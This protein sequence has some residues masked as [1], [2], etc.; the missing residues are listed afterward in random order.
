MFVSR[1]LPIMSVFVLCNFQMH[2]MLSSNLKQAPR[3]A[4]L[5]TQIVRTPNTSSRLGNPRFFS[6]HSKEDRPF[7]SFGQIVALAI[8][9]SWCLDG[10]QKEQRR[11]QHLR[12]CSRKK[13]SIG[14]SNYPPASER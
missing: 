13:K 9:F 6:D 2:A 7:L 11:Q 5:A 12:W 4:R 3:A 14:N 8:P 1:L 10:Y